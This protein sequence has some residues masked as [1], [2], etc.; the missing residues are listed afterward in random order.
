[1]INANEI[2]NKK[3][4]SFKETFDFK[5]FDSYLSNYFKTRN[6]LHIG[7]EYS[8][9][10]QHR[11]N[12]C[13]DLGFNDK[14]QNYVWRTKIQITHDVEPFVRKYLEDNGFS[15]TEKGACGYDYMDVMVVSY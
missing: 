4:K 10:E 14:A 5:G 3:E 1:M 6:Y 2:R 8:I 7:L 9:S 12:G 11:S 15:I 13:K